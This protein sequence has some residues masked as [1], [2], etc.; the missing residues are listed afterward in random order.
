MCG[1]VV[2]MST[3][4]V[5]YQSPRATIMDYLVVD[6]FRGV[7]GAHVSHARGYREANEPGMQA[8]YEWALLNAFHRCVD[9]PMGSEIGGLANGNLF[10]PEQAVLDMEMEAEF[11]QM[12]SGFEFSE[13]ALGLDLILEARHEAKAYL[14]HPHTLNH[15]REVLPFSDYWLRGL[16]AAAQHEP[17]RSQTQR[18]LEQAH[19]VCVEARKRGEEVETNQ[20]LADEAWAVVRDM[21]AELGVRAPDPLY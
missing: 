18:L 12:L 13:E 10:S 17:D 19:E 1:G 4:N 15:F 5:S 2:D 21:A 8:C 7:W 6:V 3:G 20:E 16:P 9:G 14:T 11:S